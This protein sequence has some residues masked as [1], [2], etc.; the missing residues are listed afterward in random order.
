MADFSKQYCL[1]QYYDQPGDFD[2]IEEFNRLEED[3]SV[4]FICEGFG[5]HAIGKQKG[6]LTPKLLFPFYMAIQEGYWNEPIPKGLNE[7]DAVLIDYD[8]LK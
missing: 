3:Y 2:I 4:S 8:K 7:E 5:F 6:S 1:K